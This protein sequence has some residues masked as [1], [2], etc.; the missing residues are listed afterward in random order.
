MFSIQNK[1]WYIII[2]FKNSLSSTFCSLFWDITYNIENM[3]FIN[4]YRRE[5]LPAKGR[6]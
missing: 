5:K 1:Y 2:A 4:I 3:Q 6:F